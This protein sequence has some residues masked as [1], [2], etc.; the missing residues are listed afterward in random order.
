MKTPYLLISSP[1]LLCAFITSCATYPDVHP[2]ENNTAYVSFLVARKGDG[3]RDAMKQAEAYCSKVKSSH[4]VLVDEKFEYVGTMDE[5]KYSEIKGE[6]EI[7]KKKGL[8][9]KVIKESM[10]KK[11]AGSAVMVDD[12]D[13]SAETGKGYEY[14][15]NFKCQ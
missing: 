6:A 7:S 5:D 9:P 11:K 13:K 4:A 1:F 12:D 8:V 3:N 15:L 2:L 14:T 10:A